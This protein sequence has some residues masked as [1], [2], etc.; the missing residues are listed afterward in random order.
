LRDG[1]RWIIVGGIVV[2]GLVFAGLFAMSLPAMTS[3]PMDHG[4]KSL[5][6]VR[7]IGHQWWFDAE[8]L[9]S[10]PGLRVHAPTEIHIPTGCLVDIELQSVD[11]IHSF[12]IPKLHGKV[13]LVPGQVNHIRVQTDS[14]GTFEGECGEY[15]GLQHAHMRLQVIAELPE[16]YEAWLDR[17]R[18][19]AA[20]VDAVAKG[21]EAFESASCPLCHEV[22][23]TS[24]HGQVGPDLTHVGSRARIAGGT[25]ENTPTNLAAWI[26]HAQQFKP[27]SAMPDMPSLSGEQL[28]AITA[29][30]QSLR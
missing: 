25:L 27:G 10:Q 24:A 12:W 11:V 28:A 2:P 23:G 21:R 1:Q 30:L 14:P 16:Q 19:D 29:Y 5:P 15:C 26:L 18:A 13:D 17:Q 4:S 22:R 9:S 8:Y 3:V 7:V 6:I 20:Q